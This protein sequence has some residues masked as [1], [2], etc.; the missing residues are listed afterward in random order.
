MNN[1]NT[2]NV[3]N[4][5]YMF[6]NCIAFKSLDLSNFIA[7]KVTNMSFMFSNCEALEFLIQFNFQLSFYIKLF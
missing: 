1:F 6:S 3:I 7:T 4:M 2:S 5:D